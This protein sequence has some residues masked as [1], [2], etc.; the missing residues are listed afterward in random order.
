MRSL[1][2]K[3]AVS[4]GLVAG[5]I[6]SAVVW[7]SDRSARASVRISRPLS[8]SRRFVPSG[9]TATLLVN[10]KT[11]EHLLVFHEPAPE[12]EVR[13]TLASDQPSL[14]KLNPSAIIAR[15]IQENQI[16]YLSFQAQGGSL[17]DRRAGLEIRASDAPV[18]EE[19][20]SALVVDP[21]S[22]LGE[23]LREGDLYL[24]PIPGDLG[25]RFYIRGKP[26][27]GYTV[28]ETA[29]DLRRESSIGAVVGFRSQGSTNSGFQWYLETG[30]L[31]LLGKVEN[32]PIPAAGVAL[33]NPLLPSI[34]F[35]GSF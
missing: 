18:Q 2:A 17:G 29:G 11:A 20:A 14:L 34:W 8:E 5:I 28:R 4:T 33:S 31:K 23:I 35:G 25:S 16:A 19:G 32:A 12:S 22:L 24:T 10:E 26:F 7:A 3:L 1:R 27:T 9:R 13:E 15:A 30:G 6:L 21:S